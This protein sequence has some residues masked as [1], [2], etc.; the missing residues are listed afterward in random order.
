MVR[1]VEERDAEAKPPP[2]VWLAALTE[3]QETN[4]IGE[5]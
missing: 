2:R 3:F 5:I 4:L 1:E